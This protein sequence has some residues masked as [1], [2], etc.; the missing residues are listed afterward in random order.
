MVS[1]RASSAALSSL[2]ATE[3]ALFIQGGDEVVDV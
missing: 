2:P 1:P 3:G